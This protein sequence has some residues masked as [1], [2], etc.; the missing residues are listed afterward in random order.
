MPY[1]HK[2]V[3][4]NMKA[5]IT[6]TALPSEQIL[7]FFMCFGL[8]PGPYSVVGVIY[9]SKRSR[10]VWGR[11]GPQDG[12]TPPDVCGAS[13]AILQKHTGHVQRKPRT[14]KAAII[15]VDNRNVTIFDT[16]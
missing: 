15:R 4:V 10:S 14:L 13:K 12:E 2:T 7:M 1:K 5:V 8:L 16:K 9:I 11:G 6:G 3:A